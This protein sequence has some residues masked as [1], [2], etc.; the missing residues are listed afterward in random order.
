MKRLC[1]SAL[2]SG[3]LVFLFISAGCSTPADTRIDA[4]PDEELP[5]FLSNLSQVSDYPFYTAE[6]RWD[7]GFDAYIES[8]EYPVNQFDEVLAD[9]CTCFYVAGGE[10]GPL[11]GRNFDWHEHPALLLFTY[12]PDGFAS[13]SMVDISYLGYDDTHSPMDDPAGLFYAPYYAFDGMNEHGL[14]VGM[15]AVGHAE[16]ELDPENIT[17]DSLE[18][19]RLILD[20]ARDVDDALDLLDDYNV[21]FGSV[22]LHYL[23]ADAH[24]GS[25]I[26]EFLDDE[27]LVIEGENEW[28]TAANFIISEV[29]PA[30]A[31]APC[32][33]YNHVESELSVADGKIDSKEAMDLLE[34]VSQD[35]NMGTRWST[36]Y[37]LE[38]AAISVAIN[39]NFQRVYAF[40]IE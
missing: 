9:A 22:P 15:M 1:G 19:I 11:L 25:V 38:D 6:Y 36:I 32:W 40:D 2:L 24:G 35:G 31:D 8:G 30:G 21:E 3:L 20:R 13:V 12:P 39:R 37:H 23:V 4:V 7:Y 27:L 5:V 10:D 26:I 17:L 14:A 28:Q 29:R 16:G 34:A 33:R 18:L